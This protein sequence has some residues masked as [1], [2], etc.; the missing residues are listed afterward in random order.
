MKHFIYPSQSSI[1]SNI[2][3][4]VAFGFAG[5]TLAALSLIN[6]AL[7]TNSVSALECVR[8]PHTAAIEGV[9]QQTGTPGTTLYY[10]LTI[11]NNDSPGCGKSDFLFDGTNIPSDWTVAPYL[12]TEP[13]DSPETTAYAIW[14]TSPTNAYN[15]DYDFTVEVS[16]AEEPTV[17]AVPI[18]YTVTG[19]QNYPDTTP[20]TVNIVN[21]SSG[22]SLSGTASITAGVYDSEGIAKVEFYIN[23]AL[24]STDTAPTYNYAWDTTAVANGTYT[25]QAK[26]YDTSNNSTMSAPKTVTVAN[27]DTTAPNLTIL[28]PTAGT[29]VKK[30]SVVNIS[31]EASD[32]V[33]VTRLDYYVDGFVVCIDYGT[34]CPWKTPTRKGTYQI[35]VRAQDTAGNTTSRFTNVTAQ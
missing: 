1:K 35:E 20:P 14:Y 8:A 33:G 34:T 25:L 31:V 29:T 21:P 16:R 2:L 18:R 27:Q 3:R 22:A 5:L 17:V 10:Q 9:A 23:G 30:G 4:R 32:N 24:A 7:P 6:I 11:T 26:A 28:S 13:V 12:G 15:G 19:G